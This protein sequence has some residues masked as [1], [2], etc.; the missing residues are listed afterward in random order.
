MARQDYLTVLTHL[1]AEISNGK[2]AKI[3]MVVHE[4]LGLGLFIQYMKKR[5]AGTHEIF[6]LNCNLQVSEFEFM[7]VRELMKN[8]YPVLSEENHVDSFRKFIHDAE[9]GKYNS[10]VIVF[11]NIQNISAL[12]FDR[13]TYFLDKLRGTGISVIV[14]YTD[15]GGNKVTKKQFETSISHFADS[16]TEISPLTVEQFRF[17]LSQLNYRLPFPFISQLFRISNS[18]IEMFRHAIS[19]YKSTNIMPRNEEMVERLYRNF[20]I[21]PTIEEY[22]ASVFRQLDKI[23]KSILYLISISG[24]IS[25]NDV[26]NIFEKS[27]ES[28]GD[29]IQKLLETGIIIEEGHMLR[30]SG[31]KLPDSVLSMFD[32][33]DIIGTG[34]RLL[35][36]YYFDRIAENLKISILWRLEDFDACKEILRK[37]IKKVVVELK[38]LDN[39]E[40]F[41]AKVRRKRIDDE[42]EDLLSLVECEGIYKY[43]ASENAIQCFKELE[44]GE[45]LQ[46]FQYI[47]IADIQLES[48]KFN[49]AKN[50]LQEAHLEDSENPSIRATYHLDMAKICLDSGDVTCIRSHAKEVS[51]IA[52]TGELAQISAE[53]ELILADLSIDEK[54]FNS[55]EELLDEAT[56]L[57]QDSKGSDSDFLLRLS[58]SHAINSKALGKYN[59]AIDGFESQ[60]RQSYYTG[61]RKKR[62][63]GYYNLLETLEITGNHRKFEEYLQIASN[64]VELSEDRALEYEFHR[65]LLLHYFNSTDYA[66]AVSQAALC[67]ELANQIGNPQWVDIAGFLFKITSAFHDGDGSTGNWTFKFDEQ[68]KSENAIPFYF[69]FSLTYFM[70]E[71]NSAEYM[72][73]LDAFKSYNSRCADFFSTALYEVARLSSVLITGD[74]VQIRNETDAFSK[75]YESVALYR[76]FRK[77]YD[78]IVDTGQTEQGDFENRFNSLEEEIQREFPRIYSLGVIALRG[79]LEVKLLGKSDYLR[80]KLKNESNFSALAVNALRKVVSDG[81]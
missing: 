22:F 78:V 26:R 62:A 13:M 31:P 21:P 30:I 69:L 34:K 70:L 73:V 53:A 12:E 29:F 81:Q 28:T 65:I 36:T 18:S 80:D 47:R 56:K 33:S 57:Y 10:T 39:V 60:I 17:L 2:N 51:R 77:I 72:E 68:W 67:L 15:S 24:R 32:E 59:E 54:D 55:A 14:S 19:Y 64:S 44:V 75:N 76:A 52:L 49:D 37:N 71:Q 5:L 66:K 35:N 38:T 48:G 43:A 8:F 74:I 3:A 25:V 79:F 20:P 58:G 23:S 4:D 1:S 46:P 42:F 63:F 9:E 7:P 61:D 6:E 40:L 16:L 41:V 11:S 45:R 27:T 50:T